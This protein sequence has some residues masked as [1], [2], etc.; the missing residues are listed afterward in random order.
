MKKTI[1]GLAAVILSTS[2]IHTSFI[3]AHAGTVDLDAV[4]S[5]ISANRSL[6]VRFTAQSSDLSKKNPRS[7]EEKNKLADVNN[8]IAVLKSD[9]K[10]LMSLLSSSAAP[11]S[12]P[13]NI[14]KNLTGND[15]IEMPLKDK[16][17]YIFTTLGMLIKKDV[18]T[19]KP[20]SYYIESLNK[21]FDH[22]PSY[23]SKDLDDLLILTIYKNEPDS[24]SAINAFRKVS[25]SELS[26][27]E[28]N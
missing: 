22:N 21:L 19:I 2:L 1:R 6:I 28:R 14:Q 26:I 16:E 10:H 13:Q 18:L 27:L 25:E 9:N 3:E 15:W 5:K 20:S 7:A 4:K 23:R 8:K 11:K 17:L 24:R 12:I